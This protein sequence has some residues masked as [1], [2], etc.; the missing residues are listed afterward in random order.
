M[1]VTLS[2]DSRALDPLDAT[3]F[4][5]EFRAAM[6]NP[7]CMLSGTGLDSKAEAFAF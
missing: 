3:R 7:Q 2:Y 5:E 6:E 4:L 1:T